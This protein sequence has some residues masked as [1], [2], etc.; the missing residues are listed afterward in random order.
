MTE[1]E[2]D[3]FCLRKDLKSVRQK[4]YSLWW[5]W[6]LLLPGQ[7]T[8]EKHINS[9]MINSSSE[10]LLPC[11]FS[12]LIQYPNTYRAYK[13]PLTVKPASFAYLQPIIALYIM[14]ILFL[15]FL[16]LFSHH[17]NNTSVYMDV[18]ICCNNIS[19]HIMLLSMFF[20]KSE[21]TSETA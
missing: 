2:Q 4:A 3:I 13:N 19:L 5:K 7:E 14:L 16:F 20:Q 6:K 10:G 17:V 12:P 21:Q 18:H 1:Q 15:L 11:P 9:L 8:E